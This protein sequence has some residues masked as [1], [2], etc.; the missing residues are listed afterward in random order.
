[1]RPADSPDVGGKFWAGLRLRR[2][3]CGGNPATRPRQQTLV[4]SC[5]DW[6]APPQGAGQGGG[7][8][9]DKV[10]HQQ[11]Q[12]QPRL[13]P[14][15]A[16]NR[17]SSL[18]QWLDEHQRVYRAAAVAV[19]GG[20]AGLGIYIL[21][22]AAAWHR[23][24]GC[25]LQPGGTLHARLAAASSTP[26]TP[27]TKGGLPLSL[28]GRLLQLR[29]TPHSPSTVTTATT[30]ATTRR[31]ETL[32]ALVLHQPPLRRLLPS[33]AAANRARQR[34]NSA[35]SSTCDG[36]DAATA[37][38]TT[39]A[40]LPLRLFGLRQP[41]LT[42]AA[43]ALDPHALLESSS[44]SNSSPLLVLLRAPRAE[45]QLLCT[46]AVGGRD[47]LASA[48]VL[49]GVAQVRAQLPDRAWFRRP[50]DLGLWLVEQGAA[51]VWQDEP[52]FDQLLHST[53]PPLTG[54][55]DRDRLMALADYMDKLAA[56]QDKAQQRRRGMWAD[57]ETTASRTSRMDG[58]RSW[59]ARLA[60]SL[61]HRLGD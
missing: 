51:A 42:A 43:V 24:A 59:A 1:M 7:D 28:R 61:R 56:A 16:L 40:A 20:L 10:Q 6:M 58:G 30:A 57:L 54:D 25:D 13:P 52:A 14:P 23:A 41:E 32:E 49:A 38:A 35:L 50:A 22:R 47:E 44:S 19:V 46:E 4:A 31:T 34:F 53:S 17:R 21:S 5:Q 60:R 45:V 37:A 55:R 18:Q 48:T 9:G 39:S 12:Q 36:R 3:R 26:S 8:A 15:P 2:L 11:P 27:S 29:A 33:G